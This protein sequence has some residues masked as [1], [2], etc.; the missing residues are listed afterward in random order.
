MLIVFDMFVAVQAPD[1]DFEFPYSQDDGTYDPTLHLY[2]ESEEPAAAQTKAAAAKGKPATKSTPKQAAVP[3]LGVFGNLPCVLIVV[4]VC[5]C[6]EEGGRGASTAGPGPQCDRAW[7][8]ANSRHGRCTWTWRFGRRRWWSTSGPSPLYDSPWGAIPA[9]PPSRQ[10]VHVW[11]DQRP[12]A[13]TCRSRPS[14]P[15]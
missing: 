6:A 13:C 5:W 8:G 15:L 2:L 9:G 14:P 7:K 11:G 10:R 12:P 3:V 1:T 4:V